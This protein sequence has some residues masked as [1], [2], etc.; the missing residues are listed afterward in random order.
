MTLSFSL[1]HRSG[2]TSTHTQDALWYTHGRCIIILA[3]AYFEREEERERERQKER[4][5]LP[6]CFGVVISLPIC[7]PYIPTTYQQ[8]IYPHQI[9]IPIKQ[10]HSV[11]TFLLHTFQ[12]KRFLHYIVSMTTPS[13]RPTKREYSET[14]HA[15]LLFVDSIKHPLLHTYSRSD[16]LLPSTA[17]NNRQNKSSTHTHIDHIIK[18]PHEQ[19]TSTDLSLASA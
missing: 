12:L 19:T 10:C 11:V 3:S 18:H 6:H 5:Y 2:Y 4:A 14:T 15:Q 9:P 7:H 8:P 16:P 13:H 1:G 17:N